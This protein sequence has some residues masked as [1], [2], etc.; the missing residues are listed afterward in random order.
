MKKKYIYNKK[1]DGREDEI[2]KWQRKHNNKKK[3]S[4]KQKKVKKEIIIQ[5]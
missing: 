2:A 3:I 4:G 5:A 1:K